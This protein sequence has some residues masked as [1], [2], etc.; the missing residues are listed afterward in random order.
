[1]KVLISGICGHMGREIAALCKA[2]FADASLA[3]G[4]DANADIECTAEGA[5]V[6]TDYGQVN[7]DYD[8][9]IDFSNHAATKALTDY[10]VSMN[11]P[12]IIATTGQSEDELAMI[13]SAAQKIPVFFAAN[14][15][16][17]VTLLIK[18]AKEAAAVMKDAEI[19]IVEMHHDRKLDAPSGTALAIARGIKEVRPESEIVCG[20]SGSSKRTKTEIGIS[21]VRMGNIVGEHEVLIGTNNEILRL[22]HS[23]QSRSMFAEGALTAAAF[24]CEK[25]AGLYSM[26]DL[27]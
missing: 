1:M 13:R 14:Y 8:C 23:A 4:V 10:A 17:G 3:G 25:P 27:I 12:L 16:M 6:F 24:L 11:K 9:I 7:I 21:A 18:L 5:P 2:G 19:E 15:S 22:S 26:N 20:R